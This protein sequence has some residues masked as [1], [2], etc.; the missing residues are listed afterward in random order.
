MGPLDLSAS[1][2][3]QR[4]QVGGTRKADFQGKS[5]WLIGQGLWF[6]KA[7]DLVR[8]RFATLRP[9]F[10]STGCAGNAL[11]SFPRLLPDGRN[12]VLRPGGVKVS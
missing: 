5:E 10:F 11:L 8:A 2:W 3:P 6:G 4:A 12:S 1:V 7:C 9:E